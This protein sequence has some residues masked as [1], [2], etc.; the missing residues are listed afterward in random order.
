MCKSC[1]ERNCILKNVFGTR[2][3]KIKITI[4][5]YAYALISTVESRKVRD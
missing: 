1:C 2:K 4:W 3:A 5:I